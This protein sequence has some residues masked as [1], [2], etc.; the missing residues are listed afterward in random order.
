MHSINE[1][2]EGSSLLTTHRQFLAWSLVH[3]PVRHKISLFP[4]SRTE[5]ENK[6][7]NSLG[8]LVLSNFTVSITR[9]SRDDLKISYTL[10]SKHYV[11]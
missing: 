9:M 8:Y 7:M 6:L 10:K 5:M 3:I 2:R 1:N 11:R 4:R